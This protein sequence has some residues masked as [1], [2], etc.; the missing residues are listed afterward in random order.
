M[1]QTDDEEDDEPILS[2]SNRS[3]SYNHEYTNKNLEECSFKNNRT[4]Y[5]IYNM[6]LVSALNM[7]Q[8]DRKKNSD[9]DSFRLP[10]SASFSNNSKLEKTWERNAR[11][12]QNKSLEL[13]SSINQNLILEKSLSKPLPNLEES[14]IEN[15]ELCT[16]MNMYLRKF[17]REDNPKTPPT[18]T[19]T[20]NILRINK[21]MESTAQVFSNQLNSPVN[22]RILGKTQTNFQ[23]S[24]ISKITNSQP[25]SNNQFPLVK[26]SS[27]FRTS[28]INS[29]SAIPLSIM[30]S[31]GYLPASKFFLN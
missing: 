9:V 30:H 1:T 2:N 26:N 12:D 14:L 21:I 17:K 20:P 5:Y 16:S 11:L 13:K 18:T 31:P 29:S 25:C 8:N 27:V 4:F 24:P 15:Q 23:N 10:S 19:V 22:S 3:S 6:Y 28:Q 7:F